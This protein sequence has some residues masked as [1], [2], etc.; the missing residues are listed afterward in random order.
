MS[1][2]K[3]TV[4]K[5]ADKAPR[6]DIKMYDPKTVVIIGLDTEDGPSHPQYD[7]K[8]N[9]APVIESDV[10][11]TME[12]GV[13]QAVACKRDGDRLI[14]VY[15]RGRTRQLREANARLVA[16]GRTAWLLPVVIVLGDEI[17]MLALKH[18]E[19]AHRREIDPL[20]RA[21]DAY[22]LSQKMPERQAAIIMGLGIDQFRDT[23][24]LL[25]LA[26]AAAAAVSRGAVSASAAVELTSLSEAEQTAQLETLMAGGA[27]P[28]IRDVKAK[29]RE[30]KGKAP[31]FSPAQ[32][33]TRALEHLE[34]IEESA[35]KD[36]LWAAIRKLRHLLDK[37]KSSA[38]KG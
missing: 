5:R 29:V 16:E 11:F 35:T 28:T 18:G 37:A 33:C 34:K 1:K 9:A 38:K 19:N 36:D 15:G 2:S 20:D 26:P 22:D 8:S 30:L 14:V 25:N 21:K 13:L 7:A 23:I 32:R 3:S 17:K 27:K 6:R 12:H 4:S 10:L 24:K 31:V